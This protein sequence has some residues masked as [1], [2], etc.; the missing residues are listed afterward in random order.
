LLEPWFMRFGVLTAVS[1]LQYSGMWRRHTVK[2]HRR[3]TSSH[4]QMVTSHRYIV[5]VTSHLHTNRQIVFQ[6]NHYIAK[7]SHLQTAISSHRQVIPSHGHTAILSH[8]HTITWSHR[9]TVYLSRWE[10]S[11]FGSL[12]TS[13][14]SLV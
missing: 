13:E 9:H 12:C 8:C 6:L 3:A 4:R 10:D 5:T 1:A 14:F 11:N 2:S 7:P